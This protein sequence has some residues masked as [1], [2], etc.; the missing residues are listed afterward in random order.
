MVD[1][2]SVDHYVLIDESTLNSLSPCLCFPHAG[3]C[4]TLLSVA[5]EVRLGALHLREVSTPSAESQPLLVL[6]LMC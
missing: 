4:A 6:V 2:L 5:G 1:V 3:E